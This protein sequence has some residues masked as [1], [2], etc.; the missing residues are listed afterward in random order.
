MQGCG[1]IL[2]R[3]VDAQSRRL[4]S[5][6][7]PAG[8]AISCPQVACHLGDPVLAKDVTCFLIA[9]DLR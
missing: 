6:W 7:F 3:I 8:L 5:Q 4:A 1:G 9:L 2:A